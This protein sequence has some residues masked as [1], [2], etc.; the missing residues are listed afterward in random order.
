[1]LG[2]S[3]EIFTDVEEVAYA[4]VDSFN[5]TPTTVQVTQTS[6]NVLSVQIPTEVLEENIKLNVILDY[7]LDL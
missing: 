4:A 1:M 2:T 3:I 6:N 7:T 5:V